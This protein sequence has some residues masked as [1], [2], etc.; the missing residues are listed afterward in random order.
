VRV[1][2]L[3]KAGKLSSECATS[4]ALRDRQCW[5]VGHAALNLLAGAFPGGSITGAPKIAPMQIIR[6]GGTGCGQPV[7]RSI[8]YIAC[9]GQ[10]DLNIAIRAWSTSGTACIAGVG[11]G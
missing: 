7:L 5:R 11:G 1:T 8:G 10:M 2:E 6:G 3:F 9:E 4:V